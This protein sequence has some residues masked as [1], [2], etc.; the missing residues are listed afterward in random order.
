MHYLLKMATYVRT[1]AKPGCFP[2]PCWPMWRHIA[3]GKLQ[4]PDELAWVCFETFDLLAE[5]PPPR[6]EAGMGRGGLAVQ[7]PGGGEQAAARGEFRRVHSLSLACS[8]TG[9]HEQIVFYKDKNF[10]GHR[11]E[12]DSDSSDFHTYLSRCNSIRVESGA[13]VVYEHPNFMG[14]QYVLTRGDPC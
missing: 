10:Q 1:Q 2:H 6:L 8:F 12:C 3:C 7:H 11:Y 4:L 5:P 14:Y 9:E 13:W